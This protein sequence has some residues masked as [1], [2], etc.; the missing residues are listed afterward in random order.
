MTAAAGQG[1]AAALQ[2]TSSTAAAVHTPAYSAAARCGRVYAS[3]GLRPYGGLRSPALE[4][5]SK[6]TFGVPRMEIYPGLCL[7]FPRGNHM[8]HDSW[9]SHG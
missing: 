4:M 7:K 8:L 2:K 3:P 5:M 9:S 6:H 1:A